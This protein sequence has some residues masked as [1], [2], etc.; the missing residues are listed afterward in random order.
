MN[1]WERFFD[2]DYAARFMPQDVATEAGQVRDLLQLQAGAR[3]FDQCCGQGRFSRALADLGLVPVGVDA[4][5][6]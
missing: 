5:A 3:V 6:E 2:E 4:N 1:W